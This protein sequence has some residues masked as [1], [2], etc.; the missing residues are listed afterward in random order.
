[1]MKAAVNDGNDD[2]PLD[3]AM[4][5]LVQQYGV[6]R[7]MLGAL[8]QARSVPGPDLVLSAHLRRDVGLPP[9]GGPDAAP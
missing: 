5:G 8:R 2:P 3:V 7:V 4:R 9:E 6:L 1:M